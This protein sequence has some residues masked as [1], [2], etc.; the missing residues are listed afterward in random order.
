MPD[1]IDNVPKYFRLGS[2]VIT[3]ADN[4]DADMSQALIAPGVKIGLRRNSNDPV[5]LRR[6]GQV[7]HSVVVATIEFDGYPGSGMIEIN[8]DIIQDGS[9]LHPT[10][11]RSTTPEAVPQGSSG[12]VRLLPSHHPVH[13]P[14]QRS[15]L[16][17]G[18]KLP[19]DHH[20]VSPWHNCD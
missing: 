13:V 15:S 8:M 2:L 6:R 17:Y 14:P 18:L 11:T 4:F 9:F 7:A 3:N 10:A 5:S 16:S 12:L 19:S 20:R 1:T